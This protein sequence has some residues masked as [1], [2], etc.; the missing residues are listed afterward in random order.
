MTPFILI[1]YFATASAQGGMTLTTAE[2][3]D[4]AA[5]EAGAAEAKRMTGWFAVPK[6]VCVV[7]ASAPAQP[8]P[9]RP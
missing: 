7:K 4:R 6:H 9:P 1:L 3:A 5:C 8:G 2:F